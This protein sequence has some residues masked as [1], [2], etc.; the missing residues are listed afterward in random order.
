MRTVV[1]AVFIV[2]DILLRNNLGIA[3]TKRA[4]VDEASF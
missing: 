1:R 3:D 2:R 4:S